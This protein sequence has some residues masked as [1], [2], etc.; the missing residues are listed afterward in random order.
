ML[1]P[2]GGDSLS[3][4]HRPRSRAVESIA[5]V[6]QDGGSC[7]THWIA[8]QM[9]SRADH[10]RSIHPA[11]TRGLQSSRR[12]VARG[13]DLAKCLILASSSPDPRPI[14]AC[15][16]GDLRAQSADISASSRRSYPAH[17]SPVPS[18]HIRLLRTLLPI[19]ANALSLPMLHPIP[20][21]MQVPMPVQMPIPM[22]MPMPTPMPMTNADSGQR[23]SS[24]PAAVHRLLAL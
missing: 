8:S 1:R 13:W 18:D 14:L 15:L 2:C 20:C 12:L 7:G 22:P 4:G 24:R 3:A 17:G 16:E 5:V 11:W 6:G 9:L 21:K 10:A 23:N 19:R